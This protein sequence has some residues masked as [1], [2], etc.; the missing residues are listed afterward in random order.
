MMH[1]NTQ[2]GF[3]LLMAIVV[4]STLLLIVFALSNI[5]FKEL[6]LSYTGKES[7]VAFYAADSGMEC[8][9]FWDTKNPGGGGDSAFAT[10]TP[11]TIYCSGNTIQAGM[12]VPTVPPS[13]LQ[14]LVGGGGNG[15]STSTFFI[16]MDPGNDNGPCVIVR[17]GKRYV[18]TKLQTTILSRGYN[19]CDLDNN[20]RLERALKAAY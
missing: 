18:G 5:S 16:N 12:P 1:S 2:R 3:A 20:R 7:Q 14:S 10:H 15:N 6:I 11:S 19:T 9:L 4:T 8:A 17:V 13:G